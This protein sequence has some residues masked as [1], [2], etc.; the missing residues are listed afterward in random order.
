[1]AKILGNHQTML[2]PIHEGIALAVTEWCDIHVCVV[3]KKNVV[4]HMV[5]DPE[6][7]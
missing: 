5:Q 6:N 1:M 4:L 3:S 7:K 2:G